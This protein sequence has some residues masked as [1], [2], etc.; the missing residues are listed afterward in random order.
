MAEWQ[1]RRS[2]NPIYVSMWGFKSPLAHHIIETQLY[3]GFS[4]VGKKLPALFD[5]RPLYSEVS[6][7]DRLCQGNGSRSLINRR[8]TE[9]TANTATTRVKGSRKKIV[10]DGDFPEVKPMGVFPLCIKKQPVKAA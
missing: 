10:M 4:R 7:T 8:Y 2:Q 5:F 9:M 3:K 6:V 1:T